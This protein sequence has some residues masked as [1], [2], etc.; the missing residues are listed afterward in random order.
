MR[1]IAIAG[2]L[3]L[4]TLL[5]ALAV[6]GQLRQTSATETAGAQP[7]DSTLR[8]PQGAQDTPPAAEKRVRKITEMVTPPPSTTQDRPVVSGDG[9]VP[10]VAQES[11]TPSAAQ[12]ATVLR[13]AAAAYAKITS[14]RAQFMQRRENPLLGST[15][16]SRGTLYQRD[17]DR[18][19]LKFSD[20]AGDII[21]S[22][23]QYFWLYYPSADRRQVLRSTARQGAGAVDLQSQF[24]GDPLTRFSHQYHG[25]ERLS[26]R[27][28]HVLTLTP[29]RDAG[30]KTLK[31]WVDAGDYLVRRFQITEPSGAVVEFQLDNVRLN[32]KLGDD[33]FRFTP[34]AG[35]TVIDR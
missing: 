6:R 5:I 15:N 34:P 17:P 14:M 8:Q 32:P 33:I 11:A 31:V 21:V 22:D 18:F 29:R 24:I 10:N 30:Y 12:G 25:T 16:I 7:T 20:P 3:L 23:G 19:A 9:K 13:R 2:G 28:V 1:K 26:G 4:I 35:A 27:T